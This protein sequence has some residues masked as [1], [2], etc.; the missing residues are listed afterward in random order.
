MLLTCIFTNCNKQDDK[1]IWEYKVVAIDAINKTDFQPREFFNIGDETLNYYG[2][3]GWELISTYT[4][5]ETVF[6]NFGDAQYHS[7]I[8]ANS[9][10]EKIFFIFKR[11][12]KKE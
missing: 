1:D 7:G 8:K 11:K 10:T 3:E 6:P 2:N 12:N 4:T 9:R 5:E